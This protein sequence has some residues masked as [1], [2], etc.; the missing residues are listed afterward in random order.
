MG[1]QHRPA[2][3]DFN[4]RPPRGGRPEGDHRHHQMRRISIHAL[5]EEGDPRTSQ[6][7]AT[8][9]SFQS[10]PSARR[11]T[12]RGHNGRLVPRISIH[13]LREEGDAVPGYGRTGTPY[14]NPRP[15]RGGRPSVSPLISIRGLFQSTP[16]ARRA[17]LLGLRWQDVDFISIHALR[18]EGDV[19]MLLSPLRYGISIHALRE[20]GDRRRYHARIEQADFNPRPPRGGRLH[21]AGSLRPRK[22]FQSTPSARRATRSICSSPW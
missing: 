14:F 19:F 9:R 4:P 7:T 6:P 13:A 5:R 22:T 12:R 1:R 3:S 8:P 10:T 18:E 20:E 21:G 16:S 15:P 17:T 11:A 2:R